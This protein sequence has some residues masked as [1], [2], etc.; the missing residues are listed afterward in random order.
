[1]S[2]AIRFAEV[3]DMPGMAGMPGHSP[4]AG[5]AREPEELRSSS[6]LLVGTTVLLAS[7]SSHLNPIQATEH[8]SQELRTEHCSL[9]YGF[10]F[11]FSQAMSECLQLMQNEPGGGTDVKNTLQRGS[12]MKVNSFPYGSW[13]FLFQALLSACIF[14]YVSLHRPQ[15]GMC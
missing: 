11:S 4:W 7:P 8:H 14:K 9:E 6:P 5:A 1:M 10:S 3:Q 2:Q 13:L 15:Y 12:A